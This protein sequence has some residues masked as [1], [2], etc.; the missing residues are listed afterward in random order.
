MFGKS[1]VLSGCLIF[2]F[3]IAALAIEPAKKPE[4]VYVVDFALDAQALSRNSSSDP[5]LIK[6]FHHGSNIPT[7]DPILKAKEIV[8]I[9]SDSLVEELKN[10]G[11]PSSKVSNPLILPANCWLVE[12]EFLEPNIDGRMSRVVLG[13]GDNTAKMLVSARVSE[14]GKKRHIPFLTFDKNRF[15]LSKEASE[16]DVKKIAAGIALEIESYIQENKLR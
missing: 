7:R 8:S 15:I 14:L 12:G 2:I 11:I 10:K 5:H 6:T 4:C 9:L 3:T 1:L 16:E 13:L